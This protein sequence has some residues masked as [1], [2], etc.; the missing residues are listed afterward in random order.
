[1]EKKLSGN[2]KKR[3][4]KKKIKY[5]SILTYYEIIKD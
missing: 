1:M 3:K 4:D 2:F 5:I